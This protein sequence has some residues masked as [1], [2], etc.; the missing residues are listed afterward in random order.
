MTRN[1]LG[2]GLNA[3]IRPP[4]APSP[5]PGATPTEV[6]SE[7]RTAAARAAAGS[8]TEV[9]IDRIDPNP[10]QPRTQFREEALAELAQS[11]R[12]SGI[13]QPL[14][15]RRNGDRYQ[16]IAGERRWRAALQAGLKQVPAVVRD[17]PETQALELTLV[18][19]LQREDLSPIEQAKAFDR[20]SG[21]FGMTQD[22]VAQ[23]T[24]KDRATVSNTIRLLKLEKPIQELIDRGSL[25]AGHGRAL[26]AIEDPKLRQALAARAA[27]GRMNVRQIERFAARRR[28]Q[29]ADPPA[30][31]DPN[32]KAA[33]EELQRTLGTRVVLRP[34]RG[35]RPGLLA[36]EYY[37]DQ[38]LIGLYDRLLGR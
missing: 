7:V 21:E 33:I 1:A 3:L 8:P 26:L 18:E 24:G 15:L 6:R 36:I 19:N 2:R 11:I 12:A 13:I 5:E 25:S 23:R 38:Q 31:A 30:P 9:A 27:R 37:D 29:P 4:E 32:V 28:A 10:Y 35:K 34:R 16:L 14:V 22:E 20:L 17:V